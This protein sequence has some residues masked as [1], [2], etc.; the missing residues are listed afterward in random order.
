MMG[1]RELFE[2]AYRHPWSAALFHTRVHGLQRYLADCDR[3]LDLGCGASSPL[4]W[5]GAAWSVGIDV[6]RPSLYASAQARLHTE[7]VLG[8]VSNL[9]FGSRTF[10]AVILI[11]VLEHLER[12]AAASL[13]RRAAELA[14]RRVIVTTPNGFLPQRDLKGNPWQRHR[15]GWTVTDM[16]RLGYRAHGLA[17]L[18]LLRSE[19]TANDPQAPDAIY[20]TIRWRPR[21]LWLLISALSQ[22]VT[23][24][25]PRASFEVFYVLDLHPRTGGNGGLR[26]S[27]AG[28]PRG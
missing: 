4:P 11:D 5:C 16:R 18:K 9:P 14:R 6:Y 7:Y 13:L 25:V 12:G 17:G 28:E 19:N 15:S 2:A 23:W 21:R 26:Q 8:D 22:I 27:R 1:F 20:G 10:D 24:Y 3:V